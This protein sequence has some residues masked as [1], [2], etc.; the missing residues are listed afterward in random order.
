MGDHKCQRNSKE[1]KPADLAPE[2]GTAIHGERYYIKKAVKAAPQYQPY[3]VKSHVVQVAGEP[4]PPG[5]PAQESPVKEVHLAQEE[6]Q[7]QMDLRVPGECLAL[8]AALDLQAFLLPVNLGHTVCLEQWGQEE[9][10]A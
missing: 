10:Q 4:G 5:E 3:S 7:V 2:D 9:N 8:V 1:L 6:K